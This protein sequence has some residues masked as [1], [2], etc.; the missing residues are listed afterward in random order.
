MNVEKLKSL[1][2]ELKRMLVLVDKGENIF[3]WNK[4][5]IEHEIIQEVLW[6][7]LT[8]GELACLTTLGLVKLS[9]LRDAFENDK[10]ENV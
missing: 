7:S 4:H 1:R 2:K 8:K 9:K 6:G 5:S 3:R 10:G